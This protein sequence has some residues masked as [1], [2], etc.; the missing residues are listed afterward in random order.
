MYAVSKVDFAYP[1]TITLDSPYARSSERGC[2]L[3]G[4]TIFGDGVRGFQ[5]IVTFDSNLGDLPA[6]KVDG[7]GLIDTYTLNGSDTEAKV[8]ERVV[9]ATY[10]CFGRVSN[11]IN[12]DTYS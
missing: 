9:F 4:N 8:R 7:A 2:E 1:Y 6:L 10:V 11:A 5:Y 3:F 12:F